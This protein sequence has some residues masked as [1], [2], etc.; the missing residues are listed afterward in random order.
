MRSIKKK[1]LVSVVVPAYNEEKLLARC[2]LSLTNQTF[3]RQ[4][5][6][7]I[8]VNNA[9][10]D[11]TVQIAEKYAD[12][13]IDESQK[14]LMFARQAGFQAAKGK[15]IL[16]TDADAFVPF[17]WI[18]QVVGTFQKYPHAVAVSGF[19][20]W[21]EPN[22]LAFFLCWIRVRYFSLLLFQYWRNLFLYLFLLEERLP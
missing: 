9:S 15:Y 13:V 1:L 12:Q 19:Y 11:K 22:I 6:E 16:R 8:V 18:E 17:N 5:Y 21:D 2:L 3:P 10:T 14:G 20:Y 4:D 7:V